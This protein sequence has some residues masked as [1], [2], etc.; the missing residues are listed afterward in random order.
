MGNWID[1]KS[2]CQFIQEQKTL[3]F[4]LKLYKKLADNQG[5]LPAIHTAY[6]IFTISSPIPHVNC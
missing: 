5:H 1:L 6:I 3:Y 2:Q 4:F